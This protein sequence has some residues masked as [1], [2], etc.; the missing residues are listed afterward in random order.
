MLLPRIVNAARHLKLSDATPT[1]SARIV[2]VSSEGH[3][4][5]G[6]PFPKQSWENLDRVNEELGNTWQRYGKS[7]VGNILLANQL[8]KLTEG[9]NIR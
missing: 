5:F 6:A 9:E 8:Q 2:Q 4:S 7:K 1:R 3:R